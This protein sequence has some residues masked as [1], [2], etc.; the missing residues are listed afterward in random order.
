MQLR[1]LGTTGYHPNDRRQ[2]ACLMLP[3]IGVI[4]D[5]GTGMYRAGRFLQTETLDIFLTHSHL[6]H[7]IGLTYLFSVL[8]GRQQVQVRVHGEATKLDAIAAHLFAEPI[9]PVQP[10][11]SWQPLADQVPLVG[12]GR[13]SWFKLQHP[14]GAVGYRIDWPDRSLAYVTDTT[15]D[16]QADYVDCIRGVDVLVHECFFPD[17]SKDLAQLT[18][19]SHATPV[20][21]VA[22][23]AGVARLLLV[24]IDP[25]NE[26]DDPLDL[27]KMRAIYPRTEIAEDLQSIDF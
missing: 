11:L 15:A 23:A 9:F 27:A 18:G 20:A 17:G 22:R 24:H 25:S 6:D 26:S 7:I 21:E 16:V 10:P 12:G 5:A 3:E 2:T 13:L 1:F 8:A 4:L 19:H 14:G